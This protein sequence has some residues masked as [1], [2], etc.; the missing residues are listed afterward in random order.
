MPYLENE[1]A[2]FS[3]VD[4]FS[5]DLHLILRLENKSQ[6]GMESPSISYE[7]SN[8]LVESLSSIPESVDALGLHH[9]GGLS[10]KGLLD[11]CLSLAEKKKKLA[12]SQLDLST[13]I[14]HKEK[15]IEVLK[16]SGFI[17][18]SDKQTKRT[19]EENGIKFEFSPSWSFY[20]EPQDRQIIKDGVTIMFN[21]ENA[22]L[23]DASQ[24]D[25]LKRTISLIERGDL[26]I[27]FLAFSPAESLFFKTNFEHQI[28]DCFW[29]PQHGINIIRE[30]LVLI[31]CGQKLAIIFGE[32][33]YNARVNI[34]TLKESSRAN[35]SEFSHEYDN[36]YY[37]SIHDF[38][39]WL[40]TNALIDLKLSV[41]SSKADHGLGIQILKLKNYLLS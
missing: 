24:I 30:S 1:C 13:E 2:L 3:Q 12:F 18:T 34:N 17:S 15:W 33:A 10:P 41:E 16:Y 14:D 7:N 21:I 25:E 5:E 19:L 8:L 23:N 11:D 39:E 27:R 36:H 35:F 28:L 9:I 29:D 38:N 32:K 31:N 6:V 37:D 22:S 26:P 4:L 20:F 40:K